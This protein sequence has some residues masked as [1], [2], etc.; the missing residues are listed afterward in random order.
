MANAK[1]NFQ[2]QCQRAYPLCFLLEVLWFQVLYSVLNLFWIN[3]W[4]AS[5]VAQMVK[6]LPA[7]QETQVWSLGWEDPLETDTATHSSILAWRIPMDRPWGHKESDTTEWLTLCVTSD[8]YPNLSESVSP[9]NG[10]AEGR[11]WD[12]VSRACSTV[13]NVSTN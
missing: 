1:N 6:H 7:M 5:L 9:P 8:K 13:P 10:I 11:K 12:H 4:G 2:D 3:L